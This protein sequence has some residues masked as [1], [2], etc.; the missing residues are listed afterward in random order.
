MLIFWSVFMIICAFLHTQLACSVL[1]TTSGKGKRGV[2]RCWQCLL[3]II[4]VHLKVKWTRVFRCTLPG[5][6][7]EVAT[8]RRFVLAN[9][10]AATS[11]RGVFFVADTAT[12][13]V[14]ALRRGDAGQLE[15]AGSISNPV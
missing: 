11:D 3:H 13:E 5:G 7:C 6:S 2:L 10:I 1:A 12:S 4:F 15:R 14:H 8:T 9:G